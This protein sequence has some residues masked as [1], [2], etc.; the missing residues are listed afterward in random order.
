M[1]LNKQPTKHIKQV[2]INKTTKQQLTRQSTKTTN[3]PTDNLTDK[4]TNEPTRKPTNECMEEITKERTDERKER[5]DQHIFINNITKQ[6][7]TRLPISLLT[8]R[9]INQLTKEPMN[10]PENL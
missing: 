2:V 9:Q 8:N 4:G 10:Q 1:V 6:L 5:I 7:S 3:K